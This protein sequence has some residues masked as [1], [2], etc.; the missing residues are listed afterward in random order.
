MKRLILK[1]IMRGR[2]GRALLALV[3]VFALLALVA[4]VTPARAADDA[5]LPTVK[6]FQSARYDLLAKLT[7][8]DRSAFLY[9]GQGAVILPDRATVT[10]N[11]PDNESISVVVIGTTVYVNDGSGWQR[12]DNTNPTQ[13]ANPSS[14]NDQLKQLQDIAQSTVLIGQEEVRGTLTNHYQVLVNGQAFA[15]QLAGTNTPQEAQD[16]LAQ[17]TL[18][19]DMWIGTQD[20]FIHQINTS[21][22][23]PESET[24]GVTTPAL[25]V[26]TLITY[27]DF[28][29]SNIKIV[30]P[31]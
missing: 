9:Y 1:E 5:E 17:S 27:Y 20:S 13:V 7:A 8:G 6:D 31:I 29:N 2:L 14:T 19:Y 23:I 25:E 11:T 10:L 4:P 21:L 15:D 22:N 3:G 26:A 30:A 12:T 24:N 16:L 18:K 28:N